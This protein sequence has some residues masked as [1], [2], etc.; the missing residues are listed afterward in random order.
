MK[1]KSPEPRHSHTDF[2]LGA[3]VARYVRDDTTGTVG[4][5][6]FPWSKRALLSPRREYISGVEVDA[7]ATA[8]H[9]R[10]AAANVESLVQLKAIGED[11]A[12]AFAQGRTLRNSQSVERL[13]FEK[14]S[15]VK[16]K[17]RTAIRTTLRHESGW[18]V[19]HDLAWLRGASWLESTTTVDNT[20]GAPVTLELL[21]SFSL[22]G[23]TPF[24]SDD[25]P[26][27]LRLHRFRTTWSME[28][29]LETIPLENLQLER[30]WVGWG[31]RCER[32]GAVGSMPCN[33]FFPCTAVEDTGAGVVWCAQ[34]SQP[35]SWQF[36]IYR[37]DDGVS[38]S[39]GLADREFGHWH[40]TLQPGESLVS[41]SAF[42]ACVAGTLDDCCAALVA[43]QEPPLKA[44]PATERTLPI[45]FNEWA[46]TWGK[47]SHANMVALAETLRGVGVKYLVMD[48]G[49]FAPKTGSW[50]S[51]HGDWIANAELYPQGLSAT[52]EVIRNAGMIPGLWFEMETTGCDS[53]LFHH[54]Q[55]LLKRDGITLNA[56][57]R[58]FLDLRKPA[59]HAYLAKR[60]IDTLRD[61]GFGYLKVDYNETI[62][63]GAD[64]AE[65]LG[66]GLRQHLD[67]SLAFFD[68]IRSELPDL[69]IENCSS[70]GHRLVPPFFAR[71][72]MSS[73]SDAHESPEIPIIAANL[74]RL[75]LPC[76]SQIW[77]VL[78][79]GEDYHRTIYSLTAGFLGRLCL[80]G[81]FLHLDST[82]ASAVR[83]ACAL[84]R[85]CAATIKRGHSRRHGPEVMS[86]RH[87]T[88]WQAVLRL[89]HDNREAIVVAHSFGGD[90]PR[91]ISLSL[92]SGAWAIADVLTSEPKRRPRLRARRL[93][94]P[95]GTPWRGLVIRLVRQS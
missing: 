40:K 59:A 95:S 55:F 83:T 73:F 34:L 4:L 80:S 26:G 31:A 28:G 82:Q 76:Q 69:V 19:H 63:I 27:R 17:N 20:S 23:I 70:G 39:G 57:K 7:Y 78:R 44:L 11:Y 91:E 88:G 71:T 60:V 37:R 58:R 24:A 54:K 41:P 52:A 67:G 75:M 30:S 16:E 13:R 84:Y 48:A 92:P 9:K 86:Y 74:H 22:F 45:I 14:Q 42:I 53:A 79:S 62:G 77:A 85:R 18:C 50:N 87:A 94:I 15:V 6:L 46:T 8:N 35:G 32:F 51:A 3:T 65:S 49:W 2:K 36:E 68:R 64:G 93:V 25:A 90:S 89:R 33:G 47:P 12:P 10:F 43:A 66:E 5:T 56:G 81:D 72:A 1:T 61:A 21:A 38:L 29:R